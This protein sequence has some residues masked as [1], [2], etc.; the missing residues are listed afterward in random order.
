VLLDTCKDKRRCSD[1]Q[2]PIY[3]VNRM[4]P[5]WKHVAAGWGITA[6]TTGVAFGC[7]TNWDPHEAYHFIQTVPRTGRVLAWAAAAQCR[8][9]TELASTASGALNSTQLAAQ[10][11]VA[12]KELKEVPFHRLLHVDTACSFTSETMCN[13]LSFQHM[14]RFSVSQRLQTWPFCRMGRA[15]QLS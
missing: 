2:Q 3:Q 10:R 1:C 5:V 15:G 8:Y 13:S 4:L 7:L 14:P 9:Q 11:R 12:A 6:A